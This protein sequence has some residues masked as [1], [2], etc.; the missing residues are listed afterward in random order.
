MK[1][2]HS[3]AT[4]LDARLS[5]ESRVVLTE[6]NDGTGLLLHLGTKLY[7]T[8][9]RSGVLVW[10]S[11]VRGGATRADLVHLLVESFET[12]TAQVEA[13]LDPLLDEMLSEQLVHVA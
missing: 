8:L 4:L 7:F 10:K 2:S 1:R 12:S 5:A 6:L 13:D 3:S 11:I 9:N